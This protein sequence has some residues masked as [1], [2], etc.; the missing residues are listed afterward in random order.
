M[1]WYERNGIAYV[2]RPPHKLLPRAGIFKKAS[3]L[4]YCLDFALAAD[5]APGETHAERVQFA[6]DARIGDPMAG[7]SEP[8]QATCRMTG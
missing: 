3:N 8:K 7:G 5:A 1:Q 6:L 2:A 4:N